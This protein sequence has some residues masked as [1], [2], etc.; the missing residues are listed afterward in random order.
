MVP[1]QDLSRMFGALADGQ[2]RQMVEHLSRGPA[3]VK[4][5]AEPLRLALP[6]ALKHLRVLEE[7]GLVTSQ[8]VGRVRTYRMRLQALRSIDKWVR[9]REAALHRAFDRLARAMTEL[10]DEERK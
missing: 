6:G 8:K 3:S 9:Q 5:L 1:V 10:P 4:Q 7:G 2:R